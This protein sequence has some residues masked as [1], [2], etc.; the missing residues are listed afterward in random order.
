MRIHWG[1]PGLV[2]HSV[3]VDENEWTGQIKGRHTE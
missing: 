1:E 3:S 2:A